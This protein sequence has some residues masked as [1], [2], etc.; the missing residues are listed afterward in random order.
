MA[1][2]LRRTALHSF[3]T[4]CKARMGPFAGYEMP[5]N[6]P[7]G[8]VREHLHTRSAASLFDVSHFGVVE[9]YGAD[10]VRFI[11][12]LTPAAASS[13]QCGQAVLTMFLNEH[14]G[15][16]DDCIVTK[17]SDRLVLVV[18][19]GC[20]EKIIGYMRNMVTSFRGEAV[21]EHR[22]DCAVLTLQGPKA[23]A[24]LSPYVEGLDKLLFM[25]ALCDASIRGFRVSTL[26][27]CSYS[28]EDGFDIIVRPQ[29]ALPLVELLLKNPDVLPA[30]LA[31]RDT[32][33]TEAGL[34]L[35]SHELSEEINPVAA[36]CMWCVPK[37]RLEEGGFIGHARLRELSSRPASLVPRVRVGILAGPERG[38]IP[39]SGTPV[40]VEDDAVGVVTSGIP[41]PTLGRNIAL[42]YIDRRHSKLGQP[43]VLDVRGKRIP[44]EVVQPRFVPPRYY[45]G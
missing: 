38:P 15:V 23:A 11:E 22:E 16:K 24:A 9:L 28:G 45:R 30:G 25:R 44:A 26:T 32:L 21:V 27:R 42:G 29:D 17:L 6:Y 3:H 13:L 43:V 4:S 36:R 8:A 2:S 41:S 33:R 31:A 34:N 40:F 7:S 14:A 19:A 18:N 5:I 37:H 35:Y 10:R 39:R 1:A 12:W 20:K